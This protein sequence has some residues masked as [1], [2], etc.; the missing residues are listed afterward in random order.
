M[1]F[2]AGKSSSKPVDMTPTA[3]KDLQQPFAN[4]IGGLIDQYLPGAAGDMIQGYQGATTAPVGAAEQA[5]LTQLQQYA[6]QIGTGGTGTGAGGSG[7]TP[8]QQQL[9]DSTM[10]S[11]STPQATADFVGGLGL[12]AQA[13][14]SLADFVSGVGGASQTGAYSGD[15][16]N[17]LMTA[18]IQ[19]AQRQTQQA[20]E[21]TLGRTLPGR[22]AAAGQQTQPGGSS[23]FD[24][25]AAIA[26]R[27]TADALGDIATNISYQSLQGAQAR[28]AA[29]LEAELARRGQTGLQTQQLTATA[30]QNQLDRAL[31]ASEQQTQAQVAQSQVTSQDVDTMI[32]NLQAQALPRMVEDL[33]VERSMEV[34]NNKINSLLSTLGIAAGTTRPV[35]ATQSG[36]S[37]VGMNLK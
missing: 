7:I 23:A 18:Y 5:A 11:G 10:Q 22:F 21:E 6:G 26:T 1:G 37:Q 31:G 14:P 2:S 4:V 9:L 19:A 29:A 12:E 32:K 16:N 20:L 28:E 36:S 25:A 34:F 3:F 17:P 8:A 30:K 35:V 33:G 24:R 27:G 15:P 13:Q